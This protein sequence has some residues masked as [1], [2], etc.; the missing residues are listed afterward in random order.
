MNRVMI[1]PE[2]F[3]RPVVARVQDFLDGG[4][5][6]YAADRELARDLVAVAQW[7]RG[8]VRINRVHGARV[9]G[10]LARELGIDQ[11]IDLGCGLPHDEHMHV[12]DAVRR[13]VY[14][15]SDP[16]VEAHA[17]MSLTERTGTA[18][19]LAD[20][21]DVTALLSAAPIRRLDH[22]RPIAVL[23][24]DVPPWLDDDTA[25]T[26]L[27]A[28]HARLPP[29]SVLSLTHAT[30]DFAADTQMQHLAEL[31]REAGIPFWPR[32]RTTLAMLLGPWT[33][34]GDRGLVTTAAWR[35]P[36]VAFSQPLSVHTWLDHSHAYA[37]LATTGERTT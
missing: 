30:G 28:L 16:V 12:P 34:P 1:P 19:L 20:L 31:Y 35:P 36:G 24:H 4:T 13:I 23:L 8:S 9:L 21:T 25:R 6:N 2:Y 3:V 37:A 29:G 5:D 17:R 10:H 33:L 22:D 7:L 27:Q 32:N 26:T 18:S 15:D 11:A 14:V